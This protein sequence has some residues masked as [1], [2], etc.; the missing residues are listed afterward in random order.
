MAVSSRPD[1]FGKFPST[2]NLP[3][4]S[5]PAQTDEKFS[6]CPD[7]IH[8]LESVCNIMFRADIHDKFHH[9]SEKRPKN[10]QEII[11]ITRTGELRIDHFSTAAEVTAEYWMPKP[12]RMAE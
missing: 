10:R 5:C 6:L 8:P 12:K 3:C 9:I 4:I 7:C 2:E 11:V 1:I